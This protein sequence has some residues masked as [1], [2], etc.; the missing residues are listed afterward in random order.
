MLNENE[1]KK[2]ILIDF[3]Y[4]GKNYI[5]YDIANFINESSINYKFEEYP[6]FEFRQELSKDEEYL[7]YF[8]KN[9]LLARNILR[10]DG[11]EKWQEIAK[12]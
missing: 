12:D 10:D 4:A 5:S 7:R 1:E 2:I 11:E 8:A 3:E 6:F 9:Y